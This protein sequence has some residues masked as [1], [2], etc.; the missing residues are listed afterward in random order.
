MPTTPSRPAGP[1]PTFGEVDPRHIG[2]DLVLDVREDDE[3]A[4]GHA[5][6]A[7]HV[8]LQTLPGRL[9]DLP[10]GRPIAVICRSGGRSGQASAF[11][12]QQG[13]AVRNVTGGMHAWEQSGLPMVADGDAAPRVD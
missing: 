13:F 12:A 10:A 8:P 5:P 6:D 3:W 2:E 1:P 4:A 7:M 11:L 9:A